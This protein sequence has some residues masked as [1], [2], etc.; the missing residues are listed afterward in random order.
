MSGGSQRLA[1]LVVLAVSLAFAPGALAA[2]PGQIAGT[3][4]NA[5]TAEPIGGVEVCADED[6]EYGGSAGCTKTESNGSYVVS[7]LAAG[8]YRV[9]FFANGLNYLPQYYNGKSQS[10]EEE[11]VSVTAGTTTR[12]IDAAL[13]EAGR[14]AG[15]VTD[16]STH[17][18]IEGIEVCAHIVVG[19]EHP[20]SGGCMMT[21]STG[22][23]TIVGLYGGNYDVTFNPYPDD[24]NYFVR[25]EW[26]VGVSVGTSTVD[27]AALKEGGEITGRVTDTSTG[28]PIEGVEVCAEEV[29]E[30]THSPRCEPTKSNGEYAIVSLKRD[31]YKVEFVPRGLDYF[32]QSYSNAL[33]PEGGLV[34]VAPGTVASG[35]DAALE[36]FGQI[37]GTVTDAVSKSP[38]E[39]VTVCASKSNGEHKHCSASNSS[40]EYIIP[41]VANGENIVEFIPRLGS[42][43]I[44]QYYGGHYL[45]SEAQS[46]MVTERLTASGID[47]AMQP[48][49]FRPP[50]NTAPPIVSGTPAVG[51]I[52]SCSPGSWTGT[53]PPTFTYRWL[54]AGTQ[55][56]GATESSYS[57]Q[58]A[59]EGHDIS[60][61]VVAIVSAVGYE[62]SQAHAVSASVVVVSS[63][64]AG[65]SPGG[66]SGPTLTTETAISV[67]DS[68]PSITATPV[69]TLIASKLVISGGSAPVRVACDQ[70]TCRG[71][72]ELAVQVA[73]RRGESKHNHGKSALAHKATLVLATGSFSLAQG[74]NRTVVLRLTAVGRSMLAHAGKRNPI[75]ARLVLSVKGGKTTTTPVLA[76]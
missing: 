61:E 3:V 34:T 72:I 30:P 44:T 20:G 67:T 28:A 71:S 42:G 32:T 65:A 66:S 16:S 48:N 57:T 1:V 19:S 45:S 54:R 63:S 53:P 52:L 27:D 17:Q 55:I 35:I 60:C 11:P 68:A 38:I 62:V 29:N 26:S 50:V 76:S 10:A 75:A 13:V 14:L 56:L 36:G 73:T 5:L 46:V 51:D 12:G 43:Y 2:S 64:P 49:A 39:G 24:L 31:I 33:L 18:P 69:V 40:G 74:H 23:Y 21:T 37:S 25:E 8:E 47:A 6:V 59:D 4:T 15:K 9:S 41:E 7:G 58:A 22:E 70:A